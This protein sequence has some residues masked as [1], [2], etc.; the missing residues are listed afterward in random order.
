MKKNLFRRNISS[1]L[2]MVLCKK[3]RRT[4]IGTPFLV[5]FL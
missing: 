4:A 5:W 3:E 1:F 2:G